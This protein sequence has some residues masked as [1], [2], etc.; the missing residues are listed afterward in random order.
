MSL[1]HSIAFP[2]TAS[3][4]EENTDKII[5]VYNKWYEELIGKYF[6]TKHE[7]FHFLNKLNRG[8]WN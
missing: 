6:T 8:I 2:N 1:S 7:F 4:I 3:F 5:T